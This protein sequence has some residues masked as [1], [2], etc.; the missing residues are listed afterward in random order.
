MKQMTGHGISKKCHVVVVGAGVIGMCTACSL[1]NQGVRV[2]VIDK[3]TIASGSSGRSVGVVGTQL[4]DYVDIL[5]RKHSVDFFTWMESQGLR[6]N[7]IGYLRLA[8][9]AQQMAYFEKSVDIQKTLGLR[10]RLCTPT[11]LKELVPHISTQGLAGGIFGPDNGFIDPHEMCSLLGGLIREKG[12]EIMQRSR[13]DGIQVEAGQITVS[14]EKKE[15][16][17]DYIVNAAG[18]WAPSVAEMM[19][20]TLHVY[21]ERHEAVNIRLSEPLDYVM[22]MMMDLVNG[23]G[24]GLNLRHERPGE[25]VAEVHASTGT[26][27]EDPD[28][29]NELCNEDSKI[30]LAELI[31]ERV[32]DLPGASLR[33]GWA[34]L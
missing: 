19:G 20:Q 25:L 12:G 13:I 16:H 28:H 31:M 11:Q 17:C 24:T 27:D 29:Y 7:H 21:A 8:R 26:V 34:G 30:R 9:T 4:T 22:P 3:S 2:S 23:E 14:T 6:F 32:P 18:A 5:L 1:V 10:S 33:H 15:I